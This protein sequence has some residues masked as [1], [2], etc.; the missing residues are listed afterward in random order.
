MI[1]IACA[2]FDLDGVLTSTTAEHFQAWSMLF[3]KHFKIELDPK[4][5]SLTKGV[6]RMSSLE[7]LLS[8]Y[9]IDVSDDK[10]KRLANEKN[11]YYKHLIQ[12]FDEGN[13]LPGAM[14]LLEVLKEREIKIAL[15]S[16]SKNS[17]VL[18]NR[19]KIEAY[20]DYVVNPSRIKGKPHPDIFIKA[21]KHFGLK[22][23]QCIGFEDAI[24]GIEAIKRA[25]MYAIG[26]GFEALDKADL[27]VESL[28]QL[29]DK[30]LDRILEGKQVHGRQRTSSSKNCT[31]APH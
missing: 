5:E 4:L 10:K 22:A 3:L 21:Q 29:T 16:A 11:R 6:S 31:Q 27:I 24:A 28:P 18:L 23:A 15:A 7:V 17:G 8:H 13:L 20:F 19:L 9:Q 12:S 1:R 14:R 30:L 26:V 25:R 2:I